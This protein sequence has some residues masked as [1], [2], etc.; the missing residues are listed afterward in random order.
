MGTL[1]GVLAERLAAAGLE[2]RSAAARKIMRA[3]GS[4]VV[5]LAGGESLRAAGVVVATRAPVAAGLLAGV[6][7]PLADAL[8]AIQYA[9][10]AVVSLGYARADILH[11]LDA[12][13][14][15]VPRS[16]GRKILAIS[17][18]SAKYPGRAPAGH[19]LVRVFVGG[20]LDPATPLLADGPLVDLVRR[21][22]ADVI[23]ARGVPVLVQID[24]WPGAMP[25]Y[26]VGHVDRVA[27][28]R[29]RLATLPGLA[30][31]GAAYEGVGIPQVIASGQAAA[32]A[33][34]TESRL[35]AG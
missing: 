23:G 28:I 30:L 25:Q 26:H 27:L 34:L 16:A 20:A 21:E 3:A 31:A 9:D 1:P 24:R 5:D 2:F 4:W 13:G 11:P 18:S 8:G 22:I 19:A 32:R 35:Q 33:V 7:Q 14:V 17:F 6:D 12:A 29:A 10:S 15:V